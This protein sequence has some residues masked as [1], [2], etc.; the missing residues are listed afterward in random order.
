MPNV[1]LVNLRIIISVLF[2]PIEIVKNLSDSRIE[3]FRNV[4]FISLVG[5]SYLIQ[6]VTKYQRF[7]VMRS[8]LFPNNHLKMGRP[9]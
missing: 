3:T 7:K 1:T 8:A 2:E 6:N 5:L 4:C 9:F